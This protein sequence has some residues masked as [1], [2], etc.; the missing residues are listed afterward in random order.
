MQITQ[1][2]RTN[3]F[4][5]A[6]VDVSV[7]L[8]PGSAF[9]PW[10]YD[11]SVRHGGGVERDVVLHTNQLQIEVHEA[12]SNEKKSS[13]PVRIKTIIQHNENGFKSAHFV[14]VMK[15]STSNTAY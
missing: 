4:R 8:L 11:C 2:L 3:L 9:D 14:T 10:R 13:Y 5:V 15:V 7:E 12:C 6:H 1:L